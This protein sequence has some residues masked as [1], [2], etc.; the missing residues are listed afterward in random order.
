MKATLRFD[1][2]VSYLE[3]ENIPFATQVP[4]ADLTT[5]NIGPIAPIVVSPDTTD[6]A[7]RCLQWL[8]EKQ[9]PWKIMGGGSNLVIRDDTIPPYVV[10][11]L[12]KLNQILIQGNFVKVGAG[13]TAPRLV[14]ILAS[15]GLAGLEFISGIPGQIGGLV[16]MNAGAFGQRI[17]E[18]IREVHAWHRITGEAARYTFEPDLYGYRVSPFQGDWVIL[19][20]G[21]GLDNENV[22][23]IRQ[24]LQTLRKYRID[25]QPLRQAS[26]GCAFKNPLDGK[27]SA[28]Q[29]LELSGLKGYRF[30]HCMFSDIHA[31]FLVNLGGASYNEIDYMVHHAVETVERRFGLQLEPELVFWH[32]E[33]AQG[34]NNGRL[35]I[36]T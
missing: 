11:R 16:R 2:L 36:Q 22:E 18:R 5:L 26:A 1:T 31:N 20:V 35:P 15:K 33:K 17:D 24:R 19:E 14:S 23:T 3:Q 9:I 10:V 32:D 25:T 13:I 6:R 28:G 7:Y 21:F 30:N 12:D 4:L 27:V 34:L 8:E 29:L